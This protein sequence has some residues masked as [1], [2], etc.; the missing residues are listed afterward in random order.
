MK[1]PKLRELAEAVRAIVTGPYTSKFPAEAHVPAERFRGRPVPFDKECIGCG[2]CAEVCPASAIEIVNDLAAEPPMRSVTWHYDQ[3]IFCGQCERL[4]T[5]RKGVQLSNKE[6]DL[7][8]VDRGTLHDGVKKE[9]LRCEDCGEIIATIDQIL[10]IGRKIQHMNFGNYLVYTFMQKFLKSTN[11]FNIK[12][13]RQD[14]VVTRE[15][16]FELTCPKCR[17]R[18]HLFDEYGIRQ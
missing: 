14:T 17:R 9:L 3:C 13:A 7:A 8:T 10:W 6:Y 16:F 5:T 2:A 18:M 11:I 1:Y 15:G 12:K 4:C